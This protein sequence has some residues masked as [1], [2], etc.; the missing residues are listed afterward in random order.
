MKALIF[1]GAIAAI[2]PGPI[3]VP[4]DAGT[5]IV[6]PSTLRIYNN[7]QGHLQV[8][9]IVGTSTADGSARDRVGVAGCADGQGQMGRVADDGSPVGLTHDWRA[10]G[11]AVADALASAICGAAAKQLRQGRQPA[12]QPAGLST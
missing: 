1:A 10:D 6:H 12:R 8:D 11:S 5:F 4:A 2:A 7:R 9:V 3:N